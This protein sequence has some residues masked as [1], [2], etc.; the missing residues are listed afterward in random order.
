MKALANIFRHKL[1]FTY[2]EILIAI[3]L[4]AIALVPMMNS[5]Q[6]GLQ[7]T[8]L[9]KTKVEVLHVLT[10]ELEQVLAEPFDDLDAAATTA[11]AYTTPTTYSDSGAAIPYNAF[12]W[13]YDADNADGD[14]DWFTGGEEDLLWIKVATLDESQSFETLLNKY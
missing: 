13:R 4:I 9:H 11:G 12:I 10:G 7:G 8:A 5:L 14:G 1:G 6:S 2:L 3:T